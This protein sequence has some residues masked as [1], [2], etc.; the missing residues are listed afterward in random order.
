MKA[1]DDSVPKEEAQLT[2]NVDDQTIGRSIRVLDFEQGGARL[3]RHHLGRGPTIRL[4]Q[5]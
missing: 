5:N 2:V 1:V 3:G 4:P